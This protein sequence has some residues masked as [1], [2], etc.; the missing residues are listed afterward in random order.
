M[1]KYSCLFSVVF[2]FIFTSIVFASGDSLNTKTECTVCVPPGLTEQIGSFTESEIIEKAQGFISARTKDSTVIEVG[3]SPIPG[4]YEVLALFGEPPKQQPSIFYYYPDKN[5]ALAGNIIDSSGQPF[6]L[7]RLQEYQARKMKDLDLSSAIKIGN[8]PVEVVVFTDPDCPYCRK[9]DEF[10]T[11]KHSKDITQYVFLFPLSN[12]HPNAE[13]KAR[14]I[15]CSADPAGEFAATLSGK[16]DKDAP[17]VDNGHCDEKMKKHYEASAK[18]GINGTPVVM[19][20]KKRI[21]GFNVELIAKYI[22]ESTTSAPSKATSQN[23]LSA[24]HAKSR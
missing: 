16:H 5:L 7:D 20:E 19:V 9:L 12:I 22:A 24:K 14:H 2:V 10:L 21:D 11:S 13:A 8:G 23:M 4:L 17:K 1:K 3:N 6:G 18:A 15:L